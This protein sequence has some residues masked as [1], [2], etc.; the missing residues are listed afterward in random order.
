MGGIIYP[1][2]VAKGVSPWSMV[3][4]CFMLLLVC[5]W[6]VMRIIVCFWFVFTFNRRHGVLFKEKLF[7]HVSISSNNGKIFTSQ[8]KIF[9]IMAG[10]QPR[11][12]CS[13]MFKQLQIL[14]LPCQYILSLMN[15]V[16][17]NQNSFQTNSSMHKC[18]PV[19]LSKKKKFYV[20]IKILNILNLEWQSSRMARQNLQRP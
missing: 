3:G 2:F 4:I 17:D 7:V 16:I 6:A 1:R 19:F 15:F 20:S 12:S 8:K 9:R 18:R 10:A 11:T 14:P 13:S 5:S